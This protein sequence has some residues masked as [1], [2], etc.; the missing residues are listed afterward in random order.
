ME[1]TLKPIN[2]F[3][4]GAQVLVE[5]LGAFGIDHRII[6]G[7]HNHR[8][9][10]HLLQIGDCLVLDKFEKL[11]QSFNRNNR[12]GH[13]VGHISI[14][15]P[16]NSP[17]LAIIRLQPAIERQPALNEPLEPQ[18]NRRPQRDHT[19]GCLGKFPGQIKS[20]V[21]S[22]RHADNKNF[23]YPPLQFLI[24]RFRFTLPVIDCRLL[25]INRRSTMTGQGRS[26]NSQAL[27][28]QGLAQFFELSRRGS[29]TVK[30]QDT[31]SRIVVQQNWIGA[32]D[33][34]LY[35]FCFAGHIS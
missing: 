17:R 12:I 5:I 7:M 35:H 2:Q 21:A 19:G 8:R 13:F 26:I 22:E 10:L 3:V 23:F 16:I 18:M 27:I 15:G 33:I 25:Q 29:E 11:A 28:G 14:I 6:G 24:I 32:S 9:R 20:D 1:I 31:H 34:L 4:A 30:Q